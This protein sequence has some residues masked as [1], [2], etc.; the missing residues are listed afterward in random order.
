MDYDDPTIDEQWC[1]ARREQVVAY[2]A[3]AKLAHGQVGE[4]PAWHLA[5]HA[6]IWAI[7]SLSSPGWVGWWVICGDLPSDYLSA[8]A[9]RHPREAMLAFASRWHKAAELMAIGQSSAD[10]SIGSPQEWPT[11]APLLASRA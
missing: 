3:A 2:L 7:E 9:I 1:S 4:W 8:A 11:L 5:P 6:S 10:F